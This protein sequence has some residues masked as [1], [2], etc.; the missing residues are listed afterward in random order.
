M[1][2]PLAPP[3]APPLPARP[4][5]TDP[6]FRRSREKLIDFLSDSDTPCPACNYNLRALTTTRCPECNQELILQVGLAEPRLA[7]FIT[8]L[9]GIGM[10]LG[11]SSLLLAYA[12]YWMLLRR[13]GPMPST[14]M[15]PVLSG[16][17]FGSI[18]LG[19]WLLARKRLR[20]QGPWARW[21]AVLVA[22]AASLVCP[23]WF[24]L[25]VR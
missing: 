13:G 18:L 12:L 25:H 6:A 8:G 7:W 24:I 15:L 21:C 4:D 2:T 19:F 23:I 11:F 5:P 9:V 16:T 10:G 14:F 1:S 22:G 20:P 3:T 17:V